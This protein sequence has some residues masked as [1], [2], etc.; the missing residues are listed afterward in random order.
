MPQP[1][2]SIATQRP[3][4]AESLMEFDPSMDEAGYVANQVLPSF[5]VGVQAGTF[6]RI[7]LAQLLNNADTKRS[8]GSGYARGEFTFETEAF[9]TKENGYEEPVDDREKEM[10]A[11]Y[12]DAE[13]IAAIRASGVIGRNAEKRV[14]DLVTDTTKISATA[15]AKAW[16]SP[17]AD[18]KVIEEIEAAVIAVY[19]RTGLWPNALTLSRKLFRALRQNIGIIDRIT[20]VGAGSPAKA[21]DVTTSMLSAVFDLDKIIVAGVSRNAAAEGQPVSVA[22][23]W[24][25][26]TALVS[27]C[28]DSNDFRRPCLGRTFHWTGDGS[29]IDGRV[30]TYRDE[31]VRADIVR[32]RHDTDEHLL[33]PEAAQLLTGLYS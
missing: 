25:D 8:P 18:A 33:Y 13:V 12:F 19:D 11:E 23:L 26:D 29:Q 2:T 16:N 7:P 4:I 27:V 17:A 32:V 24:P 5:P 3:D 1:T 9:S 10:F 28:S 21:T 30:E 20:A 31:T 22:Q 14:V 15:G 6:G